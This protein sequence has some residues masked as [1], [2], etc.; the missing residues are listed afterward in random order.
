MSPHVLLMSNQEEATERWGRSLKSGVAG[1][2]F[3]CTE[4]E[5]TR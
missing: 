2:S 4:E 5:E 3:F 1:M